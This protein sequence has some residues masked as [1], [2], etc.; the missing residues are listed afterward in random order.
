MNLE[1]KQRC[2]LTGDP[3]EVVLNLGRQP[4]GNGFIKSESENEF[5]YD[6]RCGFSPVSQLFQIIDQPPPEI[7][8][9]DSYAFY[10]GTSSRM[11]HHFKMFSDAIV[12]KGY[13]AEMPFVVEVGCND[14]IFLKNIKDR[15]IPHLGVEPSR[16]VANV[17]KTLGVNVLQ[18]FFNL[19]TAQAIIQDYGK[20]SVV[21]AANVMCHIPDIKGVA[22]AMATLLKPN[23]VLIFEDPYLGDVVRLGSYDQIYDEHV[24]LFSALSVSK[25]FA[26]VGLELIDVEP[27]PTHGG[28]MRYTLSAIGRRPK[29]EAVGTLMAEE[30]RQGL[31]RMETFYAFAQRVAKSAKALRDALE[32]LKSKNLRVAAYGATSKSTT[33]Y[34]FVQIDKTLI[35]CVFDNSVSKIGKLTPGTHIPIVEEA[36]FAI[37]APDVTFLAAWNHEREIIDR[38]PDYSKSGRLWLTHL[39]SARFV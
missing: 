24:F 18:D 28:S 30:V 6:L 29:T 4:L 21:V 27:Q 34:N 38:Y 37:H 20:A 32:E 26:E 2:R 12:A 3:L 35:S 16:N 7:M 39:P 36:Q 14:G 25:I 11:S 15:G 5:F 9:H 17:A 1:T 10:S 31:D 23:G 33:I 8:F 22:L 19:E 13:L